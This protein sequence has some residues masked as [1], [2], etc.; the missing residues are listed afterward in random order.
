MAELKTKKTDASVSVFLDGIEPME[1]R[2]DAKALCA[3]LERVSGERPAMWGTS[4]VGF[5]EIE[6]IGASGRCGTWPPTGFSPRA[7]NLTI[8]AMAGLDEH[9]ALLA[10][11]GKHSRSKGCLYIKRLADVDTAAL[12]QLVTKALAAARARD[13]VPAVSTR[14][15]KKAKPKQR[16][17]K[18]A[19]RTR[20]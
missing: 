14:K 11:L 18:P 7:Q 1:K 4:I 2:E 12:E 17:K 19:Q 3:M 8:Y 6:Y 10:R 15:A 16:R 13:G 9:A 5:G 20:R